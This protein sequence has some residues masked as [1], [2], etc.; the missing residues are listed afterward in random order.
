MEH[1]WAISSL[2]ERVKEK[3]LSNELLSM[4]NNGRTEKFIQVLS[5]IAL[6]PYLTDDVLVL[7]QS[8]L[9]EITANWLSSL[10]PFA[11]CIAFA[12]V[13]PY[14]PYLRARAFTF[15]DTVLGD[16]NF[17][18]LLDKNSQSS[19]DL[20]RKICCLLL[21]VL[22]LLRFEHAT[23]RRFVL[24]SR[25]YEL[26]LHPQNS[27]K[28]L[29]VQVLALYLHAADAATASITQNI[30]G[31]REILGIWEEIWIDYRFLYLWE[32]TRSERL[33]ERLCS[34][35]SMTSHNG[36]EERKP[37]I[38]LEPLSFSGLTVDIYGVLLPRKRVVKKSSQQALLKAPT[39]T[40]VENCRKIAL[41]LLH[42]SLLILTGP[43]GSGKGFLLNHV[44][45][46][47]QNPEELLTIHLNE[48][49]DVKSLIGFYS[50]ESI[51]TGLTWKSGVLTQA[52]K[53]G[54]WLIVDG[55][56][57]V[58]AEALSLL[59]SVV[60]EGILFVPSTGETVTAS[61]NFKV[62]GITR[63]EVSSKPNVIKFLRGEIWR[64]VFLSPLLK[65]EYSG[66][67]SEAFPNMRM[68]ANQI[69]NIYFH[70]KSC[71]SRE[72]RQ[73]D[74]KN[75]FE[76]ELRPK[77]M[78]KLC[79]RI[80]A[81]AHHEFVIAEDGL[82]GVFLDA[83]DIFTASIV[84]YKL[85]MSIASIVAENLHIDPRRRDYLLKEREVGFVGAEPCK[86]LLSAGRIS[87][88]KKRAASTHCPL[89]RNQEYALSRQNLILLEQIL[90][91]VKSSEPILIVGETGIGK[92]ASIQYLAKV[93]NCELSVINL[94]QQTETAD[95]VG[96]MKPIDIRQIVVSI[97]NEFHELLQSVLP[98]R[99]NR[100]FYDL[101][102]NSIAKSQWKRVLSIWKE[103]L[104]SISVS[105]PKEISSELL[106]SHTSSSRK[107]RRIDDLT[108]ASHEYKWQKFEAELDQL[109]SRLMLDPNKQVFGFVE[110]LLV[111]AMKRGEWVLLDEI[112]LASSETLECIGSLVRST[113]ESLSSLCLYENGSA[114]Q[115]RAH[116][117]FRLFA[118]MNPATE[119]GRTKLVS[120][121]R[122]CFTELY[123][124]SPDKNQGSLRYI[125][126]KYVSNISL[127]QN[128]LSSVIGLY[129]KIKE[130]CSEGHLYTGI[131]SRPTYSLRTL[132]RVLIF[133]RD[134]SRC[135]SLRRAFYEGFVL[136][137]S[138]PLQ[139]SSSE[140][141]E[142]IIVSY[143]F[144]DEIKKSQELR[145]TTY[146]PDDAQDWINQ[147]G[148]WLRRGSFQQLSSKQYIVTSHV[149]KNLTSL[150]RAISA[151]YFPILIE[152][153]TATGKTS[154]IDYL[155]SVTCHKII[156]INNHEHTDI[157][158][159]LG[160]YVQAEDGKISFEEGHLIQ[161]LRFGY[162][163]ILDELN[164][165][166]SEVLEALNRLLDDNRELLIPETQEIVKPH[167]HFV[168]FATQNPAG[169]YGGRKTLSS[170][171]RN[172]FI[173]LYFDDIPLE[174]LVT[175]LFQRTNIP[176]SWCER[177]A[178]VYRDL[179]K[180]R[181]EDHIFDH[182]SVATLRD[183]FRWASRK[184]E[185]I[186]ELAD[187]GYML[188]AE[189]ARK[190]AERNHIKSIIERI[191]SDHGP[192][193]SIDHV[194]MYHKQ[195]S[196]HSYYS[197]CSAQ[198]LSQ[199]QVVWTAAM[200][201]LY[202]LIWKAIQNNE[203]VLLVGE[204]GSGKTTMCQ[205]LAKIC[206]KTL[207]TLN[208]HQNTESSDLIGSQRPLR[209]KESIIRKLNRGASEILQ[210]IHR[211]ADDLNEASTVIDNLSEED[212]KT[213]PQ[214]LMDS[215]NIE[216][217]KLKK[218]FGWMDGSL[219]Q[220]M[221]QGQFFLLDEISLADDSVLERL[222][223]VLEP[224]GKL[225][226]AEKGKEDALVA[227]SSGFQ[228][229]AT[230]NPGGDYGKRELSPALR[231]RFTEIWVPST[232][233]PGDLLQ[234]AQSMLQKKDALVASC[235][236]DFAY[237]FNERY[238]L[239]RTHSLSIRDIATWATFINNTC[240]EVMALPLVHGAALVFIDS[241]GAQPGTGPQTM[242]GNISMERQICLKKLSALLNREVPAIYDTQFSIAISPS[243]LSIGLFSVERKIDTPIE[244]LT[245]E[246]SLQAPTARHN[247]MRIV[248]ALQIDK[249]ILLEGDPGVGKTALISALA[250]L[251]GNSLVRINLSE[252]TD[253]TDLLGSE[254][255]TEGEEIGSFDWK[256]APVLK[257]MK[258]GHWV[259]LDEINLASQ[260][261]LE[262]LNS[263]IDHRGE[264]YV[265]ELDRTFPRHSQFRLFATQ[266]PHSQGYGRK[267]LPQAFINRFT[268]VYID[269]YTANDHFMICKEL[270]PTFS[271]RDLT[272]MIKFSLEVGQ[273]I[274][275]KGFPGIEGGPWD[276]NLRDILRWISLL[277]FKDGAR[278]RDLGH[279]LKPLFLDRF[280]DKSV[281]D[282]VL[283]IFKMVFPELS[284]KVS[285]TIN[286]SKTSLQIGLACFPRD[287]L[288]DPSTR[289]DYSLEEWQDLS[290]YESML[291]AVEMA[292]PVLLVG[293]P[294][295]GK[296]TMIHSI[297][298]IT[299]M[300]VVTIPLNY[301]VDLS[302]LIGG[303]EQVNYH[304]DIRL[305]LSQL[306]ERLRHCCVEQLLTRWGAQFSA[307]YLNALRYVD[308]IHVDIDRIN[309]GHLGDI[310]EE[311]CAFFAD[312]NLDKVFHSYLKTSS[313][314]NPSKGVRF[315]WV[316]GPL[317][318]ALEEGNWVVL[319]N[320]S[321]CNSSVLDRLNSLLEKD[322]SFNLNEN[323]CKDGSPRVIK[324][325][326]NFRIFM[327]SCPDD[328]NLSRA[329]KNR[330]VELYIPKAR[331]ITENSSSR[332][333][334]RISLTQSS[335]FRFRKLKKLCRA[336]T[337]DLLRESCISYGI[338]QL[339]YDDL[340]L[341]KSFR[342]QLSV[343]LLGV[344]DQRKI[345]NILSEID[346]NEYFYRHWDWKHINKR[347]FEDDSKS[348][349]GEE[350]TKHKDELQVSDYQME[351]ADE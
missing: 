322:R 242:R 234:I 263:C 15:L 58:R 150:S 22:R 309:H 275:R 95:L 100:R 252:Q 347:I 239:T 246:F 76:R 212:L 339:S 300:K 203:P 1:S 105:T 210:L 149:Q 279:Y 74:S 92:T 207:F 320:A 303:L 69:I 144:G 328:G 131:G 205:T 273:L 261:I 122:S 60:Q 178:A 334:R 323:C 14:A 3:E 301:D 36:L 136:G 342:N 231:N 232:A 346:K 108:S 336:Y 24:P 80:S 106:L 223:S 264:C 206:G 17:F 81:S 221:K 286:I 169:K 284:P 247:A 30:V 125:V 268:V 139:R 66:I 216:R 319:S 314:G 102:S 350:I 292:W 265:P 290:L 20:E 101:L 315:Q 51:E 123:F 302:D 88:S 191:F 180:L 113:S 46:Q 289:L 2:L 148:F 214:E 337:N 184:A 19:L 325:H 48:T 110:G 11:V 310:L 57:N 179:G 335:S 244:E 52:M 327:T 175:I 245:K 299:G 277:S 267:G 285:H 297:A 272:R 225:L 45:H 79:K 145:K 109:E 70:L 134:L 341:L 188:L 215:F 269:S 259:L 91:A 42:S 226:L 307:R 278:N 192:R 187:N 27:V 331:K 68:L 182:S 333:E 229:F 78:L 260:S 118:A 254:S 349:E 121:L 9:V 296:Y 196:S 130:M 236:V 185:T 237:W 183:L 326:P 211:K 249:P 288:A 176:K 138:T 172:R 313:L 222:N 227:C 160:R 40:T 103:A 85:R 133:V 115:F 240:L 257:A 256:D 332:Y 75:Y 235:M 174:E 93:M 16:G 72:N 114:I 238:C 317:I 209:N 168:L 156:R 157:Q 129:F 146:P 35:E 47:L 217:L 41:A 170:P 228:F 49:S 266:N 194:T 295:S 132:T 167:P 199:G 71:E 241:V 233:D 4:F 200:K 348:S 318:R 154:M 12:K 324:P 33:R 89:K 84:D 116:P 96:G 204:T 142:N 87:I 281:V 298:S 43:I 271:E 304:R 63:L 82:D 77:D 34:V 59:T 155:A 137:F 73:N 177:I 283:N 38:S 330:S 83:L 321:T 344:L 248:R 202:I 201:R 262:G 50:S 251:T 10:D 220:A 255:P 26:F 224:D 28:Y 67:V 197:D 44:A 7:F 94:S 53:N 218:L 166:P 21:A 112:N 86:S 98:Y 316:D 340:L 111:K 253:I 120:S 8:E 306:F 23:Y 163:I 104:K 282:D 141:V 126:E 280:H 171:F 308:L 61:P 39:P 151:R 56:E 276:F 219:V 37:S 186:G 62:I 250:S 181:D 152:G 54:Y 55:I 162:W 127:S 31:T 213:I 351:V 345:V 147:E 135:C 143:I 293:L 158:E 198:I 270:F 64:T 90:A 190:P 208:A 29:A 311:A 243:T 140:K 6:V 294:G 18:N 195:F 230:M 117:D 128:F 343:G 291:L 124:D 312:T 25:I 287:P 338:A 5:T 99:H 65:I 119:I 193:I 189:R 159:Y 305:L 329:I 274:S 164:L 13:L 161:A 173:E 107:K 258:F 153:P 165:A 32:E 97:N